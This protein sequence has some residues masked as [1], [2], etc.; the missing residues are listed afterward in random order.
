MLTP[1]KVMMITFVKLIWNKIAYI[2]R[3]QAKQTKHIL[4]SWHFHYTIYKFFQRKPII[5]IKPSQVRKEDATHIK[6]EHV[7]FLIK[8]TH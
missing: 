4:A 3:D 7:I 2:N 5:F 6:G 1:N 8:H